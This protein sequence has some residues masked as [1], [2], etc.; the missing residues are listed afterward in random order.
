MRIS[1]LTLYLPKYAWEIPVTPQLDVTTV[2]LLQQGKTV[3]QEGGNLARVVNTSQIILIY[4]FH[5][6][7]LSLTSQ[8]YIKQPVSDLLHFGLT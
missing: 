4:F 8:W 2:V 5:N 1:F 3:V 6:S 7:A